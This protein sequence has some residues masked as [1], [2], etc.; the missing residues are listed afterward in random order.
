L[1][2]LELLF[3][4]FEDHAQAAAAVRQR[5]PLAL[6]VFCL[7]IGAVSFFA[8][9]CLVG[10]LSPLPFGWISVSLFILWELATGFLLASVLHMISDMEG[11]SGS[12]SG[13][14]ILL[15]MANLVWALL[16]PAAM[17]LMAAFPRNGW[18]LTAAFLLVGYFNLSLKA[19]GVRDCYGVSLG[20]SWMTLLLP[21]FSVVLVSGL[22]FSLAMASLFIQLISA[23]G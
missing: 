16:V 15:G 17:L 2:A 19:R 3:D 21:Y 9:L 5:R 8:S 13:L 12:A 11:S 23:L 22:V 20:R 4:F 6:G 7:V 14:F 1:N 10:R 18:P